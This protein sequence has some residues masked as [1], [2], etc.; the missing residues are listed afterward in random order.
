MQMTGRKLFWHR[1][2]KELTFQLGVI[3]SVVDWTILVYFVVPAII[4]S[5]F[6][7]RDM[8]NNIHLYWDA[9]IPVE[10][11]ILMLFLVLIRGN[12]RSFIDEA[13]QLFVLRH[14]HIF[15]SLKQWAF[16][17]SIVQ[18][19]LG[20]ASFI[21]LLLPI[22][23]R[24]YEYSAQNIVLLFIV[25]V[26]Y[27][28]LQFSIKKNIRHHLFKWVLLILCLYVFMLSWQT[29]SDSLLIV[30][31][32]FVIITTYYVQFTFFIKSNQYFLQELD[33]ERSERVRNIQ[34]IFS[35]S[36]EIEKIPRRYLKKPLF[37]FPSKRMLRPNRNKPENGLLEVLLK[38]F[39][40]DRVLIMSYLNL[41]TLSCIA[42]FFMPVWLKWLVFIFFAFAASA[43]VRSVFDR[44]LDHPFFKMITY[45]ENIYFPT[46]LKFR[47][48]LAFP[49]I[50]LVGL[51]AFV[52]SMYS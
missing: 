38:N 5:P 29:L 12:F 16:F 19:S 13:D 32:I 9:V 23:Y 28:M 17:F 33:L 37:F 21:I 2:Y 30:L 4:V 24:I 50:L 36:Q 26:A 34:L 47:R 10:L 44:L 49:V 18:L 31:S 40:R 11:L 42:I 48:I 22:F 15:Q 3:R 45:D 6:F 52:M 20:I 46:W 41:I 25:L 51:L 1:L 27:R 39:M 7:Y 35:F 43:W 14:T 8:W